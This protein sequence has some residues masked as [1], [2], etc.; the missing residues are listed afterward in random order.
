MR[1]IRLVTPGDAAAL[2]DVLQASREFLAPWEPVRGEEY[3][4]ESGQRAM[5]EVALARHE[6]GTD[7]PC[8]ITGEAGQVAGRINLSQIV[9]G[10][11][12]SCSLGY[13]VGAAHGGR[14]LASRAVADI[15]AAAFGPLRLHRI[16]AGT[17]VHNVRSRRVLERNGF[18]RFGLAPRYLSIAGQWQDHVL[19]QRLRDTGSAAG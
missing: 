1:A 11:F 2:A 18:A 10:P 14:G 8:V 7:L 13:W 3:F 19:Y 6:Q 17:L 5:I 12:E 9:R 15:V 4:T 16:Q